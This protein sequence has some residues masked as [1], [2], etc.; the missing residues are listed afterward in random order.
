MKFSEDSRDRLQSSLTGSAVALIQENMDLIIRDLERASAERDAG[1][2]G[3]EIP[4]I[5]KLH[6]EQVGAERITISPAIEWTR[7]KT[8]K[9]DADPIDIDF[10]QGILP[11]TVEVIKRKARK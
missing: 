9:D 2:I 6:I 5:V 11:I 8:T 1:D 10:R 4:V 7:K 3:V